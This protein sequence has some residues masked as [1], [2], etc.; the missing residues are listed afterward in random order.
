MDLDPYGRPPSRTSGESAFLNDTA[1][2]R[3][4]HTLSYGGRRF[5]GQVRRG[6]LLGSPAVLYGIPVRC[7]ALRAANARQ[8]GR[9]GSGNA[10][11]SAQPA[12][13]RSNQRAALRRARYARSRARTRVAAPRARRRP[14]RASAVAA[15]LPP[16]L[17][18]GPAS[19]APRRLHAPPAR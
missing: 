9:Q 3:S 1:Q 17:P 7:A 18:C 11:R 8:S 16:R 13:E 2:A 4:G 10:T 19:P 12:R 14:R 6:G 5:V 15:A